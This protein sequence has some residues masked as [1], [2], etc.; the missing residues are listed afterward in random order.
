MVVVQPESLDEV[1]SLGER[2]EQ[3][4]GQQ[5]V[6]ELPVERLR[7]RVLPRRAW[8]DERRLLALLQAGAQ[9]TTPTS[10]VVGWD[11]ALPR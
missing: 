8:L 11:A 4:T 1:P 10:V 3:L 2:R 6:L 7:V 5:L 9:A